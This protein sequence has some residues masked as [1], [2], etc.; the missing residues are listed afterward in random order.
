VLTTGAGNKRLPYWSQDDKYYCV[1][2]MERHKKDSW[3]AAVGELA[4][5]FVE[6]W[7]SRGDYAAGRVPGEPRGRNLGG[8]SGTGKTN[9]RARAEGEKRLAI[10]RVA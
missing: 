1:I 6:A 5:S 4:Q 8:T 3:T 9:R 2:K 10:Q 7:L